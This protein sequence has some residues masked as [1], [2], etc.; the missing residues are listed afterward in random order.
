M[1]YGFSRRRVPQRGKVQLSGISL[2]KLSP[3][4]KVERIEF[5][6]IEQEESPMNPIQK[7]LAMT[8]ARK[9][10]DMS[11]EDIAHQ[12]QTI[13][14]ELYLD[15]KNVGIALAKFYDTELGKAM[16]GE[17][18]QAK[19]AE[20]QKGSA[21]GDGDAAVDRREPVL[22]GEHAVRHD[23]PKTKKKPASSYDGYTRDS[24]DD[25]NAPMNDQPATVMGERMA[26]YCDSVAG[27]WAAQHGI[28]KHDAY[29]D[30]LKT[31]RAFKLVWKAAMRIGP[32]DA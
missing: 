30:L 25:P 23:H 15:S 5:H 8:I 28:S 9:S 1:S 24:D 10:G 18:A 7:A 27:A 6:K 22:K 29:T 12:H 14:M 17:A 32:S 20:I 2:S 16:L 31:D 3:A 19:Y 11:D 13:A 26:K 4:P 21:C